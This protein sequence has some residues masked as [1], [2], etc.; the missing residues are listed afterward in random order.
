MIPRRSNEDATMKISDLLHAF[1]VIIFCSPALTAD[2]IRVPIDY[3]T[4]QA[5]INAASDSDTILVAPGEY[6][7]RL[8]LEEKNLILASWFLT[9]GDTS[10]IARTI[11]DGYGDTVIEIN[12]SAGDATTIA[13]FT[14]KDGGDGI[15][16][17]AKIRVLN[18]HIR[19]CAD[20]I[21]YGKDSGG[22]CRYNVIE[23]NYGEGLEVGPVED[24]VIEDNIIRGNEQ[25]GI[26][27]QLEEYAGPLLAYVIRRNLIC[28][29]QGDGLQMVDHPGPSERIFYIER[30]L[31]YGNAFSG[32]KCTNDGDEENDEGAS[33]TDPIYLI[34]N[35]FVN[36]HYGVIGGD[37]MVALN[38]LIAGAAATA[39]KNVDGNSI[40]SYGSFWGN[41]VDL[42]N[43]NKDDTTLIY[44]A[45]L[46]DENFRITQG[47][48]CVDRGTAFF[49]WQ[50]DTALNIPPGSF[51]GSAPDIGAFEYDPDLIPI[52]LSLLSDVA[53]DQV[54]LVWRAGDET[55]ILGFEIQRSQ[56][57]IN[58]AQIAFVKSEDSTSTSR[59]YHFVDADLPPGTYYYRLKQLHAD[60]ESVSQMSRPSNWPHRL[61]IG[62]CPI[63]PIRFI[64]EHASSIICPR[65]VALL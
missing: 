5:G 26:E 39:M 44:G 35:T 22:V 2:I 29:N 46:L 48:S 19:N 15:N 53:R 43:C 25:N 9:T 47:S 61:S 30:N 13:G 17:R 14:I 1:F 54:E 51:V 42:D 36:N 24:I 49:I 41:G 58:L 3:A 32:L 45:P 60:G 64:R 31:F 38:N 34:G 11:I 65:P 33:I 28:A 52:E 50:G 23:N 27:I 18:N 37:N 10:Y 63:I 8:Q 4:I 40:V 56:D 16:T 59:E 12:G 20:G 62:S 21:D 6:Q 7:E 57:G 55:G